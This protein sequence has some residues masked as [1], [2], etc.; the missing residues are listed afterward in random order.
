[1]KIIVAPD[2]FK[3]CLPA[4]RVAGVVAAAIRERYPNWDVVELPLA[5]GG[6]GTLDTLV[7]AL[8]GA[9]CQTSV[10]DPLGRPVLAR[11]GLYDDTAVIEVAEACG[12]LLLSPAERNPL[13]ASTYGVGELLLAASRKGARHFLIGLGGTA[14]CD[15][16]AGMLQVPGLREAL[17][18]CRMELLCDVD[19]PFVGSA[20]AAH[21]FAPQKGAS[22]ADVEVLENRL[23]ALADRYLSETSV[24]VRGLPGAG[25]AGGLGG[26]LMAYFGADRVSGIDRILELLHF[27]EHVQGANLIVTG[28]GK[29]D[30]QTLSGKV[31]LGVLRHAH[32]APVLL[33][34]GRIE[35]REELRT[36]GFS[37]LVQ[38]SPDDIP[39]EEAMK[40]EVAIAFLK[41][42]T[43]QFMDE[44][45]D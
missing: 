32:G 21:V 5:D 35:D 7:P 37:Q 2:S 18:G 34:S 9:F 22:P 19:N 30:Y 3:G 16:G 14:T 26:A 11:F 24:D 13:T 44:I 41:G 38:V 28:E 33:L 25:A 31:P 27:D 36:A 4:A 10:S 43:G 23:Q 40:P 29:S 17:Q 15:G 39:L 6:E 42:K 12:L 45:F 20:G 1:M 8:G